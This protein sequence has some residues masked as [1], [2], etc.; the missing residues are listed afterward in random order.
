MDRESSIV[1]HQLTASAASRER[2]LMV[3]QYVEV[4]R[5]VLKREVRAS[6]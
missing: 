6:R 1:N 4:A 5:F 3:D 2:H